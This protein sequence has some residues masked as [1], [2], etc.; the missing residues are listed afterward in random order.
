MITG[1]NEAQSKLQFHLGESL[2]LQDFIES[3]YVDQAISTLCEGAD[4]TLQ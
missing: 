2:F 3:M 1:T 4:T